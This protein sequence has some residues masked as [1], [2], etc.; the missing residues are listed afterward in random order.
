MFNEHV[1]QTYYK[2]DK[3]LDI[4]DYMVK[5]FF[6]L[7]PPPFPLPLISLSQQLTVNQLPPLTLPV[8][9]RTS[10]RVV[11]KKTYQQERIESQLVKEAEIK[12]N[13]K[14]RK[15]ASAL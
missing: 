3:F 9:T 12:A 14:T 10:R 11:R 8:M 7:S 13:N 4:D 1:S 15:D 6:P 2:F 5:S